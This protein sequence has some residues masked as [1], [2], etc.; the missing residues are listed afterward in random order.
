M[1]LFVALACRMIV[2]CC[3]CDKAMGRIIANAMQPVDIANRRAS[4]SKMHTPVDTCINVLY[5]IVYMTFGYD[6]TLLNTARHTVY[7]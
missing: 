2:A 7:P 6:D 3:S 5:T 4:I 1:G